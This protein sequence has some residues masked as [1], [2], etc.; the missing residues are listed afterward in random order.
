MVVDLVQLDHEH[1]VAFG[2]SLDAVFFIQDLEWIGYEHLIQ[3]FVGPELDLC[4]LPFHGLLELILAVEALGAR[5]EATAVFVFLF[6]AAGRREASVAQPQLVLVIFV[7]HM[8]RV[9]HVLEEVF[10]IVEFPR[11]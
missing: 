3:W 1:L 6:W 10:V 11:L 5:H 9:H 4:G 2:F 8:E 7:L